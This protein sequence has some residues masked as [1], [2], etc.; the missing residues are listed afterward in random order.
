MQ[1]IHN[2]SFS[3]IAE[4]QRL[5]RLVNIEPWAV[6]HIVTCSITHI[7]PQKHMKAQRN[8]HKARSRHQPQA[9][10]VRTINTNMHTRARAH[11]YTT[12]SLFRTQSLLEEVEFRMKLLFYPFY[13][14]QWQQK[15]IYHSSYYATSAI[16]WHNLRR[17][18][19]ST[20]TK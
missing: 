14:I 3:L 20:P 6:Q 16:S 17:R 5:L 7:R 13:S 12:K 11:T 2:Q 15:Q 9:E 1:K 4:Q 18:W 19:D 10:R 8:A